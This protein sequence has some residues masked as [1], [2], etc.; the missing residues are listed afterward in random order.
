[1]QII[2]PAA[3]L[4]SRFR[5]SK[6]KEPKPLISWNDKPMLHHVLDN[7]FGDY[8]KCIVVKQANYNFE[9]PNI[10]IINIDYVTNGPATTAYIAKHLID[11]DQDLLITN[12]DQIIKDWNKEQFLDY[13]KKYDGILGCFLS[14]DAHNSYVKIDENKNIIE[15][16]EKVVISN[17]ATTGLHYWKKARYFFD[18]Y[19]LMVLDNNTTNNEYYIAPSY[20]YL[21]DKQYRISLY[22]FN[23]HFPVGTPEQLER[24]LSNEIR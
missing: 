19:D 10:D 7:F 9:Y 15:V 1:M 23:Q 22:M 3:G 20:Q 24:Y 6:F 17:L 4:G 8:T 14:T 21:I 2:I 5:S 11:P 18:S 13:A 16:K 12:C